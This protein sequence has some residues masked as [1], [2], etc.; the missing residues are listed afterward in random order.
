MGWLS[1]SV[2]VITLL[3]A[4][5]ILVITIY[6]V[7][8][9]FKKMKDAKADGE[10][11]EHD[12]DGIK[13]FKNDIPIGWI[14]IF[15]VVIIWGLWYIFFGYPLQSFSQIGQYNDE[16]KAYNEKF[17]QQWGSLSQ[18]DKIAMGEGIFLVQCSQC[19][20]IN[21]EGINGK[22]Q[23]L[24]AWGKEEGIINTI[25]MGSKG[26]N[27]M[28]GEMSPGLVGTDEEKRQVA[29]YV[30][31]TFSPSKATKY[32]QADVEAGKVV[33][34]NICATCHGSDGKGNAN[35]LEGF[36]SDLTTYGDY[37]FVDHVLKNGK[38][39]FIGH[40]PSFNYANFNETQVQALSAYIHS[41]KIQD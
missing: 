32:S 18:E 38:K 8:F 27:Y 24:R 19:H 26:L 35:G 21:A 34:E 2:N 20:G 41:L 3:G 14:G 1:D 39:G 22:A 25:N 30:M 31:K 40:M 15:V 16:V 10:L 37:K 5:A 17:E 11:T 6:V 36:A 23:N 13:E 4:A 29:A 33:Y 12:W 7:G 28:A 9:Y